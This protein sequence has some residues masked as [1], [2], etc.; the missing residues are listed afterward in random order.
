MDKSEEEALR[1]EWARAQGMGKRLAREKAVA[2]LAG[3]GI[4]ALG[5]VASFLVWW[6]WPLNRV[7]I[8]LLVV[9][10]AAALPAAWWVRN[11]LWPGGQF[12]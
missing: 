10:L 1:A 8:A 7:P 4:V 3:M 12:R 6:L 5:C 9:P 11:K 2:T